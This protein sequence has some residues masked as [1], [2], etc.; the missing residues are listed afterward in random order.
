MSTKKTRPRDPDIL[1]SKAALERAAK[2][3]LRIGLETGTPVWV[4]KEGRIVDLTK[5]HKK[6]RAKK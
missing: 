2:R 3:A 5:E 4:M 6:P 1:A